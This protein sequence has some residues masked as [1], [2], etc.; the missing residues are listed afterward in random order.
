MKSPPFRA[1]LALTL[2]ALLVT[3]ALTIKWPFDD[4]WPH[5]HKKVEIDGKIKTI[6]L[7]VMENR[8]F[9]HMVGWMKRFN[10]EIDGL[11]GEESNPER[12]GDANSPRVFVT[13]DA[14]YV[15]PDPGHSFQAIQEE[16]F[17]GM[18]PELKKQNPAPMN[19]FVQNAN[20]MFTGFGRRVMS[21]FRPEVVSSLTAL[22]QE[23]ALFDRWFAAVP[24]STQPNRLFIHSATSHG[25]TW[26]D[27][28]ELTHGFPQKTIFDSIEESGLSFGIYFA[29]LPSTLFFK[30]LRQIRRAFNFHPFDL[31]FKHAKE[32]VLPNYVVLEPRYFDLPDFPANDD[33]PSHDVAEGQKMLK[34]VYEALRASPQWD[35]S[36]LLVTYDEHGGFFDHVPTPLTGIPNPDGIVGPPPFNFEFDR[37]G[38]RVATL[39]IS[40]W[41]EKGTV[42]H[43]P[44]LKP[45]PSSQFEHSSIPATVKKLFNLTSDFL[46]KRDAWAATFEDLFTLRDT[47]RTDCPMILPDPPK[48]LRHSAPTGNGP[49]SEWQE[50]LVQLAA[51]LTEDPVY[52]Y[53]MFG[54]PPMNV[55]QAA[56]YVESQVLTFLAKQRGDASLLEVESYP[57]TTQSSKIDNKEH[58]SLGA[59]KAEM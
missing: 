5:H 51:Q 53:G 14:E 20:N 44:R 12:A 46:T 3:P 18:D 42:V 11:T 35:E 34:Q 36:L 49:L 13:D 31:F 47:P 58:T 38:V 52:L 15:D 59:E 7:L 29:N 40:P 24:S 10:P 22:V 23:F 16:V 43:E 48:A 45:T 17:G 54:Q 27:H 9:D 41:V 2:I 55:N 57:M 56:A 28:K 26:N 1:L 21:A 30:N 8:S 4:L 33:H 19:G 37:L 39:A 32:G 6:V 50:E 25:A